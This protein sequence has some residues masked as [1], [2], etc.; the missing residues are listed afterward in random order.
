MFTPKNWGNDPI[1][2]DKYFSDGLKPPTRWVVLDKLIIFSMADRF[3]S[4]R[5]SSIQYVFFK[6]LFCNFCKAIFCV[7]LSFFWEDS[8]SN[9]QTHFMILMP[10]R[11][12]HGSTLM[13]LGSKLTKRPSDYFRSHGQI[14]L[15]GQEKARKKKTYAFL[16]TGGKMT[17]QKST[18]SSLVRFFLPPLHHGLVHIAQRVPSF[19]VRLRL[20]PIEVERQRMQ[21]VW[22]LQ[23]ED[24]MFPNCNQNRTKNIKTSFQLISTDDCLEKMESYATTLT[25]LGNHFSQV[26]LQRLNSSTF[27]P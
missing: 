7:F 27:N 23:R 14:L 2:T 18:Y 19:A 11:T 26:N 4:D 9:A 6:Y 10:C 24:R 3:F 12:S 13:A 8:L 1:L 15:K 20:A 5:Y 21:N 17:V 25:Y 16:T 22:A